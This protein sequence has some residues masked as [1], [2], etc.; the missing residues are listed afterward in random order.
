MG[1]GRGEKLWPW[2]VVSIDTDDGPDVYTEC[3][4][5]RYDSATRYITLKYSPLS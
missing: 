1:K 4:W 3:S 2:R 5:D